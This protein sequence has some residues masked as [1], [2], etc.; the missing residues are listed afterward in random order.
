MPEVRLLCKYCGHYWKDYVYSPNALPKCPKCITA[1]DVEILHTG[2]ANV[3][4][5]DEDRE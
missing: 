2:K 4:G 5:Y 3:Y 1:H